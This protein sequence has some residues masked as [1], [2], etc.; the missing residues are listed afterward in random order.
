MDMNLRTCVKKFGR[1]I[2]LNIHAVRAYTVQLLIAI[3]HLK[4]N[5][6]L[7]ADIKPDNILVNDTRTIVKLC[8]FGSAMFVGDNEVTPYIV[9][10]FYRAPEV[11][12]GL[13]YDTSVDM[14]SMGCVIYE[15]FTGH[16]LFPGRT[17][18]EMMK[19][20]MHVKGSF[21]KKM[22]RRGVFAHRHFDISDPNSPFCLVEDPVTKYST[23]RTI[24]NV[25]DPKN[26]SQ[27]LTGA[28]GDRTKVLQL[29]DLLERI[30]M[31]DPE[32][33]L[34]PSQALKHPFCEADPPRCGAKNKP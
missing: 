6:V 8:D 17:N 18:N 30:I 22:L 21:P 11:I 13:P 14:W 12:L 5:G 28:E 32:K 10:R 26:F 33:R 20:I 31:L 23:K 2:G 9:S 16:I 7:H 29:A 15:L 19:L 27:L 1:D 3:K 4:N 34:T 25:V 24:S